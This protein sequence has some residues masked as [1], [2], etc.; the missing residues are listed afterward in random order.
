MTRGIFLLL[1]C[2]FNFLACHLHAQ[3]KMLR[4]PSDTTKIESKKSVK[5]KSGS[6]YE[7]VPPDTLEEKPNTAALYSAV[8]PGLGQIY[9][10]K[11]WKLPLLY[12]GG[13]TLAY[14][15]NYNNNLY[16]QY[17][18]SLIAIK[19]QDPRTQPIDDRYDLSTY[20]RVTDYWRRNRDL[21]ILTS[22]LV[23]VLN[24]VDAHVDAH[25][26]DFKISDDLTLRMDPSVEQTVFTTNIV[27]LSIKLKLNE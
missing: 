16:I 25:L 26:A 6:K 3:Q 4:N 13:A 10:K 7:V 2:T 19:D 21:V 27:G 23:Y 18:N 5:L 12:A 9:N 20:E 17:R 14:F 24:I 1:L 8:L 11:Y 22:L 15:L